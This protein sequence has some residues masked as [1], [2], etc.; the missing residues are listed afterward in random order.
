M[1]IDWRSEFGRV[2]L[3]LDTFDLEHLTVES[4]NAEARGGQAAFASV[5]FYTEIKRNGAIIKGSDF[6]TEG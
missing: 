2:H 4:L 5:K 1:A 6:R 3:E